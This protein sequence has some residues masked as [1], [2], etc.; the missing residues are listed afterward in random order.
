MRVGDLVQ[1][2]ATGPTDSEGALVASGAYAQTRDVFRQIEEALQ[3]LGL[4]L[5][6]VTRLRI[7][8]RDYGQ[9]DEI[10]RAQHP[11]F[12]AHPP[13]CSVICVAGFHIEGMHVYIEA[14]AATARR[15]SDDPAAE[16]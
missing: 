1:V 13:A 12:D 3:A 15:G 4:A 11:L 2:S 14:E 6:D 7:Y 8:L 16:R 10:L 9:L 5:K